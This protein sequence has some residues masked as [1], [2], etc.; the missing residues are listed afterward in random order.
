VAHE[1]D[2][3]LR[4]MHETDS[5]PSSATRG[6]R[7]GPPDAQG[8]VRIVHLATGSDARTHPPAHHSAR[9][10]IQR[11]PGRGRTAA[12]TIRAA[13][14]YE[15]TARH[16]QE[17]WPA[18][19]R[20]QLGCPI[21]R[22]VSVIR[23]LRSD[24]DAADP[25]ERRVRRLRWLLVGSASLLGI[26]VA[27]RLWALGRPVDVAILGLL[28]LVGAAGV[29]SWRAV[30]V[31]E[32]RGRAA[33]ED[34]ARLLHGIS[35]AVSPDGIVNAILADVGRG[36]GADHLVVVQRRPGTPILDAT[37]VPTRPGGQASSA[38]LPAV[39]LE[40]DPPPGP[41]PERRGS[42]PAGGD[43]GRTVVGAAAPTAA[44][45]GPVSAGITGGDGTGQA[46]VA[47]Q[48]P[49]GA[50]PV[51]A[52]LRGQPDPPGA[53][54]AVAARV[55]ARVRRA[56]GISHTLAVP[57]VAREEI[58]G[59]IVISR[60]RS[61]AWPDGARRIL[62]VAAGEAAAALARVHSLRDAQT[63]ASTDPLTGLPNRRYFEEYVELMGRGRRAADAIGILMVDVDRFKALN[64]RHG[65]A[66]GDV[67]LRAIGRTIATAVRDLDVPAR[68]GGEEFVVLLRNASPEVALEVGERIRGAVE[69]IDLRDIGVGAVTV[70]VG[71]S[72]TRADGEGV[73][74]LVARADHALYR[75]KR[76]G[77]NRVEAA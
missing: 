76:Y 1:D 71:A 73:A 20:A 37:L 59:V 34:M 54:A 36:T 65:H 42:G 13:D 46:L 27:I 11:E 10:C 4:Q 12:R 40:P 39:D 5:P 75:A 15:R 60:R 70:S 33:A 21:L 23:R 62:D 2:V 24:L 53:A 26:L 49:A 69:R 14:Q 68:F 22:A 58:L 66:I 38:F 48:A 16:R 41:A 32:S 19:W 3:D 72:V 51:H 30:E 61:G 17:D 77:R 9:S 63:R 43:A 50:H 6:T 18:G 55:E 31:R 35:R 28:L 56:F 45:A 29:A 44:D 47:A 67:V 8:P 7:R 25:L 64:D 52:S 57:L 74:A